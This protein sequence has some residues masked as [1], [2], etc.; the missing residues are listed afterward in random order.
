MNI[1]RL[2]IKI[3][4]PKVKIQFLKPRITKPIKYQDRSVAPNIIIE[5]QLIMCFN[6]QQTFNL[7]HYE[8]RF[9]AKA[10]DGIDRIPKYL[11]G[12]TYPKVMMISNTNPD[13]IAPVS[14]GLI[15][16]WAKDNRIRE[17]T[18]NAKIETLEE[19]PSFKPYIHNR[20]L[21]LADGFFECK[22]LDAKGKN[23]QKYLLYKIYW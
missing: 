14:W 11:N 23:K 16:T 13:I 21:I 7:E 10:T 22:W 17:Y 6:F 2:S 9:T 20:C 15:P 18:L 3:K 8:Y 4:Y 12:F 19:K 1:T 5:Y